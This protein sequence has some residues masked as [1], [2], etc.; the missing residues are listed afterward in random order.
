MT[1][2]WDVVVVGAGIVGLGH[3][4]AAWESGASVLVIDRT[5]AAVGASVRNFG[6]V[7]VTG[8]V[9]EL[10]DLA[11]VARERWLSLAGRAG[12]WA[13]ESGGLAVARTR[14]QLAVLE[15]VAGNSDRV[16]L[17]D[18]AETNRA[19]GGSG[20]ALAGL[21]LTADIRVDPRTAVPML[22]QWFAAQDRAEIRWGTSYLGHDGTRIQT[23]RGPVAAGRVVICANFDLDQLYPDVAAEHGIRRCLLQMQRWADPGFRLRPAV[24]TGSSLLRYD[25]F[26]RTT[27]AAGVRAELAADQPD[28]LTYDCNVMFTQRPDGT[29]LVGDSHRYAEAADPFTEARIDEVIRA[30]VSD[31]LGVAPPVLERWQGVYAKAERPYLRRRLDEVVEV[32]SV[33]TGL[34]MTIGLGLAAREPLVG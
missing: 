3:A 13:E 12:F 15:E 6:H 34:G 29:L 7:C 20:R 24:L 1:E 28:L 11:A 5:R 22:G 16:R 33:T 10:A 4:V 14:A 2:T 23:S 21:A 8:Q 17:L 9:D 25:A 19:L 27:A 32:C 31:V 18:A 30:D 26:S